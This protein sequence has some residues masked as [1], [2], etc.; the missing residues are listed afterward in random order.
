MTSNDLDYLNELKE[1]KVKIKREVKK[2]FYDKC[3]KTILFYS[4]NNKYECLFEIPY[5]TFGLPKYNIYEIILY[6]IKKLKKLGIKIIIVFEENKIY[7]NWQ[8]LLY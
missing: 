3:I 8:N 7:I 5:I 4:K 6:I 2:Y 1:K